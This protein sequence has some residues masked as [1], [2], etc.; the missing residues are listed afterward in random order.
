MAGVSCVL[1]STTMRV[2]S[3]DSAHKTRTVSDALVRVQGVADIGVS[4]DQ[5]IVEVRY[6]AGK[7]DEQAIRQ[8]VQNAGFEVQ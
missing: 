7:T 3:M 2:P 4:P 6:D 1:Q 8:A 5:G